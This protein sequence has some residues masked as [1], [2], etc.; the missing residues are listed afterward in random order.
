MNLTKLE[1]VRMDRLRQLP[2]PYGRANKDVYPISHARAEFEIAENAKSETP[3]TTLVQ[4]RIILLRDNGGLIW[5]K[6]R[7]DSGEI[8]IAISK[9]DVTNELAFGIAKLFDLGDIIRATGPIRRTKTNEVTVWAYHVEMACKSLAHPPDKVAGLQDVELRYRKRYLDMAFNPEFVKTAKMRSLIVH[10]LRNQMVENG[11]MEVETPMLH[12]LAGGAAAKPFET[13]LNALDIPLFLRV[14]PELYLKRLIVGGLPAVFEINRNFRNEGIDAT[15]NPEFT[16][17]EAYKINE[18][19]HSL[20]DSI[21]H[22]L[23]HIAAEVIKRTGSRIWYNGREID[24]G[25]FG[26]PFKCISYQGTYY[27][28]TGEDLTRLTDPEDFIKANKRFEAEC[29]K[30]ID[31]TIPTFVLGYPSAISP[32]TR[33]NEG[34]PRFCQRADLFIGGMEVGT[35]YT[36]QNDPEAQ[37]NAFSQQL[38]G[39]DEEAATHRNLDEDFIEA[40]KV[41]MPP[42]GGWAVGVD[43]LVMLLTGQT[44]VRD[45]IAFPFMRPL[46]AA[47][48]V[49]QD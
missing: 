10:E 34:D 3:V 16:S 45:V 25:A 32:L 24:F 48:S 36:E 12:T 26:K 20:M 35:V 31:P 40:L 44:S 8:Q 28:V 11:Y 14:A 49:S 13:H 33:P 6:I 43:R 38:A 7:D 15:H 23:R 21:A 29:E 41:G 17:L 2:R 47:A 46:T 27:A 19:V 4:G 22:I 5:L 37:Y 30:V 1:Q 42:T 18:D 39:E 9:K